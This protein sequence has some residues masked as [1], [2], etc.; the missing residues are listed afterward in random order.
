MPSVHCFMKKLKVSASAVTALD[1]LALLPTF[2][3]L[4]NSTQL[5]L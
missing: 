4:P 2:T 1:V 5:L 3:I